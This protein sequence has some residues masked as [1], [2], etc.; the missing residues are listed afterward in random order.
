MVASLCINSC[1]DGAYI[2]GEER[3]RDEDGAYNVDFDGYLEPAVFNEFAALSKW[4]KLANWVYRCRASNTLHWTQC[5]QCQTSSMQMR[6]GQTA[7]VIRTRLHGRWLDAGY[8]LISYRSWFT[9]SE[10]GIGC[11]IGDQKYAVDNTNYIQIVNGEN[12]MLDQDI[13][14]QIE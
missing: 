13:F 9:C 14:T 10:N 11:C 1:C 2:V 7:T 4:I 3:Q 6:I 5:V 12:F 8:M